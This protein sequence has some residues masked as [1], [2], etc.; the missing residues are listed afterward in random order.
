MA[1]IS[2]ADMDVLANKFDD[3]LAAAES[4]ST[5]EP[6]DASYVQ[7]PC[8][9]W[10]PNPGRQPSPL[11]YHAM[12]GKKSCLSAGTCLYKKHSVLK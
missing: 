5:E 1:R 11:C 7:F 4:T 9:G 12:H 8:I 2:E 10:P 3:D 6:V